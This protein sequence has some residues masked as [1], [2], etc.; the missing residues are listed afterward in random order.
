MSPGETSGRHIQGTQPAVSNWDVVSRD[1]GRTAM[2][3]GL[4]VRREAYIV[5][6]VAPS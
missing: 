6:Y 2:F 4:D 5:G 3:R 1:L